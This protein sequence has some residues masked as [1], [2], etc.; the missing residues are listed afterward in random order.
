MD[1]P[2]VSDAERPHCVCCLRCAGRGQG[3][4]R[5][6][7]GWTWGGVLAWKCWKPFRDPALQRLPCPTSDKRCETCLFHKI[8]WQLYVPYTLF[9][10]DIKKK[11]FIRC[12]SQAME[13][14]PT[15]CKNPSSNLNTG[16]SELALDHA[17]LEP[18]DGPRKGLEPG[19]E[20]KNETAAGCPGVPPCLPQS[21]HST[22]LV[23]FP[24]H[25]RAHSPGRLTCGHRKTSLF[26]SS[27][28]K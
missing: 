8:V 11:C 19:D 3:K 1:L 21:G 24:S 20:D 12:L 26:F 18:L 5:G 27:F 15:L 10:Q 2:L 9:S 13:V 23:P 4:H 17:N 14:E 6:G 25:L 22:L 28:T 7:A 16:L